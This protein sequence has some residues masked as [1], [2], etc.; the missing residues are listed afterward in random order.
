MLANKD[1]CFDLIV[2]CAAPA[3]GPSRHK[4]IKDL[5]SQV[6]DWVAFCDLAVACR[7]TPAVFERL[8]RSGSCNAIPAKEL[9]RL[10]DAYFANMGKTAVMKQNLAKVMNA[11]QIAGI[12]ALTYKG[13]ILANEAYDDPSVRQFDDLDILV[14]KRDLLRAKHVIESMGYGEIL[15]LPRNIEDSVFRPSKP[16][17]L[18]HHDGSHDIDLSCHILHDYFS[19]QFPTSALWGHT[20]TVS[21]DGHV[22]RTLPIE[23]LFL[24]L[25]L[26]GAKH[27]W[28]RP[29]WVADVA[30]LLV[31]KADEMKWERVWHLAKAGDAIRILKLGVGLAEQT[32]RVPVPADLRR[33]LIADPTVETL[34]QSIQEQR[35]TRVGLPDND[36]LERLATHL[37][38]RQRLRSR[39]RYLILRG[40]TPSYNDWRTLRLPTLLY[41]LYYPFRLLRLLRVAATRTVPR[42]V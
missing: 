29:A 16:Y 33:H 42:E 10:K 24:F 18:R 3:L 25:C 1:R 11:L 13:P 5:A 14:R 23:S 27:L 8:S 32:Y 36:D 35:R 38:L 37:A 4:A 30:G 28:S 15:G 17:I 40:T 19:F 2:A 31:R 22:I 21:L 6:T 41:P 7:A 26:H 9:K 12:E 39:I 34:L 20:S